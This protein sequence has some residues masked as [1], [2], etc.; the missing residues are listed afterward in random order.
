MNKDEIEP[1][2]HLIS[3]SLAKEIKEN[4]YLIPKTDDPKKWVDAIFYAG[5]VTL[6][7]IKGDV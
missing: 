1:R 6:K 3:E 4:Y 2:L 5:R 7:W